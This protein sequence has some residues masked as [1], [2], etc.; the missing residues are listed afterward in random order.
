MARLDL[1]SAVISVKENWCRPDI[2]LAKTRLTRK[3]R[4]G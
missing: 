4:P 3:R 1:W 2:N